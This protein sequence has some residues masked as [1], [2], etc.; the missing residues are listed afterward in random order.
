MQINFFAETNKKNI[1]FN[2]GQAQECD[3]D[4]ENYCIFS[5]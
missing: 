5:A 1:I 4:K 2:S 3:K